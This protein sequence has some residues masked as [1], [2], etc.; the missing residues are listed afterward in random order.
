ML[1]FEIKL[2]ASSDL[3]KHSLLFCRF[4]E[5]LISFAQG[6][7][8]DETFPHSAYQMTLRNLF[9][10]TMIYLNK[11][12]V[13]LIPTSSIKK[14]GESAAPKH[15]L[16][17]NLKI[18][19]QQL[20]QSTVRATLCLYLN[21]KIRRVEVYR[22]WSNNKVMQ[23]AQVYFFIWEKLSLIARNIVPDLAYAQGCRI[24]VQLVRKTSI[25]LGFDDIWEVS[26]KPWFSQIFFVRK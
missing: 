1:P 9:L 5:H 17:T 15:S 24:D 20:D 14:N 7:Y 8:A 6:P 18:F 12:L 11:W 3:Y 23:H 19:E 25:V 21:S 2:S 26:W 4:P 22:W 10:K 16:L 13:E